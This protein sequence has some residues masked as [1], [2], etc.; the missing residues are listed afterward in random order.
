M[1]ITITYDNEAWKPGLRSDWGFSCLVEA[2]GSNI[3][4]DT[5]ARGSILLGNMKKLDIDPRMIKEIMIF[6]DHWDRTGGYLI[7]LG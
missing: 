3:L 7:S 4:F 1:K 2:F 5:G 6:H